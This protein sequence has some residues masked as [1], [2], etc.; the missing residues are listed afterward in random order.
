MTES[1]LLTFAGGALGRFARVDDA[2]LV[3]VFP[4]G[5]AAREHDPVDRVALVFTLGIT[6][7]CGV[8]AGLLPRSR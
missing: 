5:P 8:F 4:G 6:V 1:L 7:S 2:S 3:G